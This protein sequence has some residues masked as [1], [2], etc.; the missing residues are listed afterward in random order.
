MSIRTRRALS[1]GLVALAVFLTL[2]LVTPAAD[3]NPS[4]PLT[5]T[6]VDVGQGDG[7]WLETPDGWDVLI[8]AGRYGAMRDYLQSHGVADVEVLVASHPDADHIGGFLYIL[9]TIPVGMALTNGQTS[10][11]QTDQQF[12]D[13]LA[14]LAIPITVA[15]AGQTY[16]W[17]CCVV[18]AVLHPVDPLD[19]GNTNDNSI[20]LKVT[21]GL[22]DFIFT[23]D[24]AEGAEA[25][26]LGRGYDLDSEILKVSHHG[27][28]YGSTEPFLA[29]VG[30][31]EAVISVGPNAYGHPHPDVLARLGTEGARVWRTDRQGSI[32]VHSN[33]LTYTVQAGYETTSMYL[34]FVVYTWGTSK[35]TETLTPYLH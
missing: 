31:S 9:G 7:I 5:I 30:P 33:G 22:V 3:A 24:V 13:L 26:I 15:R 17:G 28:R 1:V 27:S 6:F 35:P 32:I 29:A 12:R 2:S 14:Q 18:A 11:T 19:A 34:P 8:D 23:S 10:D 16:T 25:A 20:V 4:N 21:Y